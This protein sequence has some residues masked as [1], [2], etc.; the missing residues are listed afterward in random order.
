MS[1]S[2]RLPGMMAVRWGRLDDDALVAQAARSIR[3]G[4]VIGWL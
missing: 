2:N 4:N 3:D 1:G